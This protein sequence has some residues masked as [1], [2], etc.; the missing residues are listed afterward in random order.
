MSRNN[1]EGRHEHPYVAIYRFMMRTPAWQAL[2]VGARAAFFILKSNYNTK[3]QN[4][5]YLPAR[6]GAKE[7]NA[8]KDTVRKWMRELEH[9]G[10][11]IMVEG[12][13]LGVQGTGKAARYRLTDSK[14]A[15]KSATYDFQNWDGV[16]FDQQKQNPVLLGRTPRPTRPDKG[17]LAE[18]TQ[19]G[20]KC[21][22][23]PDKGNAMECPTGPDITSLTSSWTKR[24]PEGEH[25]KW[26]AP[27]VEELPWSDYW[28]GIYGELDRVA[29]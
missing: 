16:L 22:A 24:R 11:I 15:G 9:Y 18:M 7:L 29:A 23:G 14:Y 1:K 10:F 4:S 13:H 12:A 2:S 28:Q 26:S 3:A 25:L 17:K 20:N 6:R 5:V 19:K 8:N 27:T 21:P